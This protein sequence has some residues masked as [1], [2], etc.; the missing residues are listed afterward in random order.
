MILVWVFIGVISIPSAGAQSQ[1]PQAIREEL[2]RLRQEFESLRQQYTE[3]FGALEARLVA[4]KAAPGAAAEP[5][6]PVPPELPAP[7]GRRDR[8]RST[9]T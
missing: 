3:R 1:T 8:C 4:L 2:D 6:A 9:A 5:V 7:E